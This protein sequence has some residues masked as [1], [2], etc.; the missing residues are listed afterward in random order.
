MPRF[1]RRRKKT[2]RKKAMINTTL[3][4]LKAIDEATKVIKRVS[5]QL[6]S[7]RRIAARFS[8]A[9]A[10]MQNSFNT[11]ERNL[12]GVS[13]QFVRI[14]FI[15]TTALTMAGKKIYE[16]EQQVNAM[17]AVSG[18]A[19]WEIQ[20]LVDTAEELGRITEHS[21]T[22]AATAG[23]SLLRMGFNVSEAN[24]LMKQALALA[25]AGQL[26]MADAAELL[27]VTIKSYGFNISEAGR[28]I[29]VFSKAAASGNITV[30]ESQELMSKAGAIARLSGVDFEYLVSSFVSIRDRGIEA[31]SAARGISASIAKFAK[32]TKESQLAIRSLGVDF[33]KIKKLGGGFKEIIEALGKTQ[34]T[35][36][37]AVSIFGLEHVKTGLALVSATKATRELNN[38][39]MNSVGFAKR[40]Q[41]AYMQG[42][43]GAFKLFVSALEGAILSVG[44]D[45]GLSSAM[46]AVLNSAT[47]LINIFNNANPSVK[48]L[49]TAFLLLTATM[50]G[51][52]I[53]LKVVA[54]SIGGLSAILSIFKGAIIAI[55]GVL[56]V[57]QVINWALAASLSA[58]GVSLSPIIIGIVAFVGALAGI[59]LAYQKIKSL[60]TGEKMDLGG[61][62]ETLV[63]TVKNFNINN[64]MQGNVDINVKTQEGVVAEITNIEGKNMKLGVQH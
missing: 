30:A 47:S 39:L 11:M 59:Y 22:Q 9:F 55:R 27:G 3:Y 49:V 14:G 16:F 54:F 48:Q 13:N 56:V 20:G 2:A 1:N 43:P 12:D 51:V 53:I 8:I 64:F 7:T 18:L 35:E 37:E 62:F 19:R 32:P 26:S 5:A 41:D 63:N 6:E 61:G 34:I 28:I 25:T 42:L 21:A 50:L 17:S 58:V 45:G 31:G 40:A 44:G 46:I 29:D 33:N 60:I 23:V 4:R 36:A 15:G 10:A 24:G 52:G 38:E 57:W